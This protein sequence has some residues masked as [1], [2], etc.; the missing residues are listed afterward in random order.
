MSRHEQFA[1]FTRLA[2]NAGLTAVDH[3]NGH[4]Q[5]Q[6]GALLVNYYP[7]TGKVFVN[8]MRKGMEGCMRFAIKSARKPPKMV[9]RNAP[10]RT[11]RHRLRRVRKR[12]WEANPRCHWCGE[13]LSFEASTIDHVIP[14]SRSGSDLPDNLVLACEPCNTKRGHQMPELN[15]QTTTPAL[16]PETKERVMDEATQVTEQP[17]PAE[18]VEITDT[19]REEVMH[20]LEAA[21]MYVPR[22]TL[23]GWSDEQMRAAGTWAVELDEYDEADPASPKPQMPE[24]LAPFEHTMLWEQ[25]QIDAFMK[26]EV[27]AESQRCAASQ[28]P[29]AAE[30]PAAP[31]AESPAQA[32]A[33]VIDD[34]SYESRKFRAELEKSKRLVGLEVRITNQKVQIG[35][36]SLVMAQT[37]AEAKLAKKEYESAVEHLQKLV[38]EHKDVEAAPV[39]VPPSPEPTLFD[40]ASGQSKPAAPAPVNEA[41]RSIPIKDVLGELASDKLL[42]VLGKVPIETLGQMADWTAG[43]GHRLTDLDGVGPATADKLADKMGDWWAKHPEYLQRPAEEKPQGQSS[44]AEAVEND[45]M[46]DAPE[47]V[48]DT[49]KPGAG[50]QD[51]TL[52]V[53]LGD[54]AGDQ[55]FELLGR[56]DLNTA[57]QLADYLAA[58]KKLTDIDGIGIKT[59]GNILEAFSRWKSGVEQ[60]EEEPAAATA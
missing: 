25:E 55:V 7:S 54:A 49:P 10:S 18:A 13:P 15:T 1:D 41:W 39:Y 45:T 48:A 46:A 29:A 20:D 31:Q 6:G 35:D 60:K 32:P 34:Q 53:V 17:T 56:Q 59:A 42:E 4:W 51:T 19:F 44:P 27:E 21:G 30:A 9:T 16:V 37:Q 3:G 11:E 50:L 26:A 5:L 12:L 23:Y 28:Q 8:G 40:G 22:A 33:A 14:R 24:H 2:A 38:E 47:P 43:V 58:G 36:L 57:G 52:F